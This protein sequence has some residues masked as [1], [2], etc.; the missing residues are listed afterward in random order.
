VSEKFIHFGDVNLLPYEIEQVFAFIATDDKGQEG[1]CCMMQGGLAMPLIGT[2]QARVD[3][4]MPIAK[5]I[6]RHVWNKQ[7]RLVRFHQRE[8]LQLITPS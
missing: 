5:E 4:L 2:D 8:D 6:A 3:S 7:I 1:V